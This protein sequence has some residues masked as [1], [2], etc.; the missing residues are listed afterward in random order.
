MGLA[1]LELPPVCPLISDYARPY[2]VD[3]RI[4]TVSADMFRDEWPSGFDA[5][6]FSNV[7]HDWSVEKCRLLAKKSFAALPEGG[8]IYLHESLLNDGRDGPPLPALYSM[9]MIHLSEGKQYSASEYAALLTETGF[10]DISVT[11]TYGIFSFVVARK[12]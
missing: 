5:H 3:A 10:V 7:F 11:P 1:V 6:L 8:R 9:V 4:K 2:G 12:P